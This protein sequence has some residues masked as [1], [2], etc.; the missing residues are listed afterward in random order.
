MGIPG[1][2]H[3]QIS[4]LW[5]FTEFEVLSLFLLM[6]LIYLSKESLIFKSLFYNAN[7]PVRGDIKIF[8]SA[9]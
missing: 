3:S 8:L 9:S 1:R 7:S 5:S 4:P 2:T 6:S